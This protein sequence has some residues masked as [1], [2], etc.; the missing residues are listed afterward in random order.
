M[1][2][3]LSDLFQKI[4]LAMVLGGGEEGQEQSQSERM[5]EEFV[6]KS[7]SFYSQMSGGRELDFRSVRVF[8]PL[9]QDND[10]GLGLVST[11]P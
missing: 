4:V 3:G 11:F 2:L 1:D 5:V 7:Q 8:L 6:E 9:E 10:F